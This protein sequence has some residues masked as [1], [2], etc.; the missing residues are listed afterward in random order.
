[1]K[2]VVGQSYK[3]KINI[4]DDM[5]ENFAEVTGDYNPMHLDKDYAKK[6][7]F[8]KP[9]AHGFLIGSFISATLGNH[10]PGAGT[11]YL[12]QSMKFLKP[13]YINDE[14]TVKLEILE[15]YNVRR[16][17][18][19]TDCLNHDNQLILDGMAKVILPID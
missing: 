7:I 8:K 16:A 15:I 10:F 1:M 11:I 4:T 6:T 14:I 17:V 19:K 9:I 18:I 5:I 3:K 12:S 2:F 13:V